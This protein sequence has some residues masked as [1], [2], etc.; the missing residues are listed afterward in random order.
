MQPIVDIDGTRFRQV[1]LPAEQVARLPT[2]QPEQGWPLHWVLV[3]SLPLATLQVDPD[4]LAEELHLSVLQ[5]IDLGNGLGDR[6]T[7][8]LELESGLRIGLSLSPSRRTSGPGHVQVCV[9]PTSIGRAF[10]DGIWGEA[11][12][13]RYRDE[14]VDEVLRA[15]DLSDELVLWRQPPVHEP[16]ANTHAGAARLKSLAAAAP[17]PAYEAGTAVRLHP[18]HPD[19]LYLSGMQGIVWWRWIRPRTESAGRRTPEPGLDWMYSV[20]V[21]GPDRIWELWGDELGNA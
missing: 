20:V 21:Q 11:L 7:A 6:P 17:P 1:L 15:L 8:V 13:E 18:A 14:L 12:V 9:E 10:I 2:W 5:R 19:L 16:P 4:A 3:P